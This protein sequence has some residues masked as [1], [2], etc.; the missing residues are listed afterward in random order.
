[1]RI[2]STDVFGTPRQ[3]RARMQRLLFVH[4]APNVATRMLLRCAVAH[5]ATCAF[6][7]AWHA[8]PPPCILTAA[9]ALLPRAANVGAPSARLH[10]RL[11]QCIVTEC[12][13]R[14]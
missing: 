12:D 7:V 6:T 3:Q 9:Y 2:D 11:H 8:C 10:C 1:M 4:V 14:G 13:F 5:I